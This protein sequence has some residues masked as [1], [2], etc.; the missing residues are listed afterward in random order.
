M[1]QRRLHQSLPRALDLAY[2]LP[3]PAAPGPPDVGVLVSAVCLPKAMVIL[4][5]L[6]EAFAN[7]LRRGP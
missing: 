2:H 5:I 6:L 7:I 4:C 3:N 1:E